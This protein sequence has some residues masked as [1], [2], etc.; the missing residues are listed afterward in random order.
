VKMPFGR[1][2]GLT[3]RGKFLAYDAFL[4]GWCLAHPRYEAQGTRPAVVFVCRDA[5]DALGCARQADETMT[6]RI[7]AMGTPPEH[8]YY[9]GRDHL[10][11]SVEGD[12]T[13]VTCRR[14]PSQPSRLGYASGSSAAA[15]SRSTRSACSLHRTSRYRPGRPGHKQGAESSSCPAVV[16][17]TAA[18]SA[19]ENTEIH[20]IL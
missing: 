9:A 14:L 12:T 20:R 2:D 1:R 13:T 18:G 8:W 6:G 4:C 3:S 10:F 5:H 7:G 17:G 16:E 15:N 19:Q 11:F